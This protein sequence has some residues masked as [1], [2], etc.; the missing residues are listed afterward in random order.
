MFFLVINLKE[1][2]MKP[3]PVF[4][5]YNFEFIVEQLPIKKDTSMNKEFGCFILL[6]TY[7]IITNQNIHVYHQTYNS[8]IQLTLLSNVLLGL[9]P[10]LHNQ[11]VN[12]YVLDQ[13]IL[14]LD[15]LDS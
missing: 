8:T 9:E 10:E 7:L 13:N 12:E 5:K 14:W 6:S 2:K 1:S 11:Y 4:K 3:C 15:S